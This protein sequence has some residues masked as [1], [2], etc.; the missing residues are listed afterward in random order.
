MVGGRERNNPFPCEAPAGQGSWWAVLCGL[1]VEPFNRVVSLPAAL[2]NLGEECLE[3]I[4]VCLG[5]RDVVG[6]IIGFDK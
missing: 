2:P 5:A 6:R 4:N 1:A 3:S